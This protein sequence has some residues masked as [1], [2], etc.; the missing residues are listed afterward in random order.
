MTSVR[1][2]FA[3]AARHHQAGNLGLAEDL[4]RQVLQANPGHAESVFLLGAAAYQRADFASAVGHFQ[5]AV[6]LGPNDPRFSQGLGESYAGLGFADEAEAHYR[7]A[8]RLQPECAEAHCSLGTLHAQR[9]AWPAAEAEFRAALEARPSDAL[10]CVGLGNA[11][12]ARGVLGEAATCYAL[13]LQLNPGFAAAFAGL[14]PLLQRLVPESAADDLATGDRPLLLHSRYAAHPLLCRPASTDLN[15][16]F[17]I[18]IEREYR[19]L[20]DVPRAEFILDCGAYVGYSSAYLLTR[21]PTASL[22]AVEPDAT[23]YRPLETNMRPY[24]DRART[25]RSAVWSH[26]ANLVMSEA[27]FR[28]GRAWSRQVRECTSVETPEMV[29]VDVGTI[30]KESG[31]DRISILKMDIEGAETVVFSK[32]FESWLGKVDAL[33]IELHDQ[34]CERAFFGAIA[35]ASFEISRRGELVVCQR[36]NRDE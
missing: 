34:E 16:F 31:R 23:N 26:P 15:V 24:G 5:R 10:A 29:G 13:A 6:A 14:A 21:F 25:V 2:T 36:R 8:L 17:Q 32:N 11:L 27:P 7:A 30:L 18:F 35:G 3:N 28:D 9:R 4:L 1:E 22:V 20:D 33:A 19:C 12:R